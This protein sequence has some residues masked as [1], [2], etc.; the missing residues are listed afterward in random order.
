[1]ELIQKDNGD[2]RRF[3]IQD[4]GLKIESSGW[5]GKHERSIPFEV[6]GDEI[7]S[8]NFTPRQ[9]IATIVT[10]VVGLIGGGI[11]RLSSFYGEWKI[12]Y[13][14]II[15]ILGGAASLI[16][17]RKKQFVIR[18]EDTDGIELKKNEPTQKEFEDFIKKLFEKRRKILL[19]KYGK[20]N[21]HLEYESQLYNFYWLQN[22]N[23]INKEELDELL[24][25]LD[26][27][28][29]KKPNPIGFI[30]NKN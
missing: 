17:N 19:E 12:I 14:V 28:F 2:K 6:I 3:I 25:E 26:K 10:I 15:V 24:A 21:K 23:V 13:Y 8:L 27:I 9:W 18:C 7:I 1:M 5:F 30:I 4:N 22:I 11:L 20:V 29:N 16:F